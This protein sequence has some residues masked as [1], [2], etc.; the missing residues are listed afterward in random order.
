MMISRQDPE[1]SAM[2]AWRLIRFDQ[3]WLT[4]QIGDATY[5]RSLFIDGVLP[6]EARSRLNCLK[7]E[8]VR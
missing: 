6:N 3:L 5:L 1:R 7:M 2:L 8:S 4:G